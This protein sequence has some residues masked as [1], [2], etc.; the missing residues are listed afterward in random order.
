QIADDNRGRDI[1][2]LNLQHVTPLVDFFVIV[3][4]ASR[5]QA[6]AIASD[7]DARMKS[8]GERKLGIEGAE[9]G[10]WVLID[11]GD[12]VVHIF[13]EEAREY[14]ALEDIWGDAPRLD[15][16]DVDRPRAQGN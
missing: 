10:R 15:W 16:Q 14:Y 5:R 4:A 11:Y 1:L 6:Q 8:I 9:E 2:L 3:S 12:F 13:S 7:V